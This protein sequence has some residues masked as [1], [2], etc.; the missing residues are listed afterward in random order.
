MISLC[1]GLNHNRCLADLDLKSNC[2][3]ARGVASLSSL[4]KDHK[5]LSRVDLGNN[6]NLGITGI[7]ALSESLK[8][9]FMISKL[10]MRRPQNK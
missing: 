7:T 10:V 4:L 3:D 5:T 8:S 1:V 6:P 9:K 2:I